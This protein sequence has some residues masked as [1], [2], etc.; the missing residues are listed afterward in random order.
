MFAAVA[1]K[2]CHPVG[3]ALS[4]YLLGEIGVTICDRRGRSGYDQFASLHQHFS[5]VEPRVQAILLTTFMKFHNLYSSEEALKEDLN[6][7]FS[8]L[9]TSA[10]LEIQQ[11]ACEYLAMPTI[12][13]GTCMP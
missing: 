5:R 1:S 7:V 11:R 9:S 8:R 3:V 6:H 4:A 12:G 13:S 10:D 2:Y